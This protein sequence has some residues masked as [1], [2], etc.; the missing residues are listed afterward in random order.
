M[1]RMVEKA[2]IQKEGNFTNSSGR[3]TAIQSLRGHFDPL[4]I[5]KLTGHANPTPI[6]SYSQ[7]AVQTQKEMFDWLVELGRCSTA[8]YNS[9]AT[10]VNATSA[11]HRQLFSNLFNCPTLNSCQININFPNG[12]WLSISCQIVN[13]CYSY[14][15]SFDGKKRIYK[16]LA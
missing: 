5:S 6:Q 1:K 4:A 15:A 3:K 7:N 13:L 2:E 9:T 8:V 10:T 14:I 12:K 16:T 11:E